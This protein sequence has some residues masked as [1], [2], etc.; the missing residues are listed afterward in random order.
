M[1]MSAMAVNHDMHGALQHSNQISLLDLLN[2]ADEAHFLS[3]T[4]VMEARQVQEGC[5]S[6]QD[7][8]GDISEDILVD[9]IPTCA[10]ALHVAK[11]LSRY[12]RG[13]VDPFLQQL[14]LSLVKF[15][16]RTRTLEMKNMRATK[17]TSYF[18][19]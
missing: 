6:S 18:V 7:E 2:P 5:Q 12:I 1:A 14:D 19:Q 3:T 10:E 15:G 13:E 17:I 9:P 4:T 8:L 11:T 16:Q